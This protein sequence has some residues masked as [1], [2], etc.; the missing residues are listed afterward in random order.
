MNTLSK[1]ELVRGDVIENV[2]G[3]ERYLVLRVDD[4]NIICIDDHFHEFFV[5]IGWLFLYHR[6]ENINIDQFIGI[7]K[8]YE[9]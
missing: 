1:D 9:N 8:K 4:E 2:T 3:K 6:T 5:G 7:L